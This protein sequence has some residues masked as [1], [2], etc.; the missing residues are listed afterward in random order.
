[1]LRDHYF[2]FRFV[3]HITVGAGKLI[4]QNQTATLATC[5]QRQAAFGTRALFSYHLLIP[6]TPNPASPQ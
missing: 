5:E 2:F 3:Q 1:M 6:P 4:E